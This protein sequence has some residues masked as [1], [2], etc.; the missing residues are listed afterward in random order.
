MSERVATAADLVGMWRVEDVAGRG[1]VDRAEP[2]LGFDGDGRVFG[3]ASV[4]RISGGW[5]L[6]GGVLRCG[7][8][9]TT[10]MAGPPALMAQ[11]QQ[12][13]ALLSRPLTALLDEETGL[14]RLTAADA[15]ELRL[16][17][18]PPDEATGSTLAQRPAR[19]VTG[20]LVPR[21][22]V[23]GT[24]FG[25]VATV[26]VQ[27]VSRADAAAVVLAEQVVEVRG[28]PVDYDVLVPAVAI[29]ERAMVAVSARV[30]C[31]GRLRWVSDT[32][33]PVLTRGA[34]DGADVVLAEVLP[35]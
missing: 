1:V 26:R 22:R 12:L 17:R 13:T 6:D 32:V 15:A 16:V 20:R 34:P 31:D 10:L 30:E 33:T 9:V 18:M 29:D 5:S 24:P 23:T 19:C 21:E 2:T 4:N 27:D 35:H 25:C 8:L 28:F 11:E 14:L 3:N 7:P